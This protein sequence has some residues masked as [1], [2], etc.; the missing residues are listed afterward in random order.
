VI[1][2]VIEAKHIIHNNDSRCNK[3]QNISYTTVEVHVIEANI[4]HKIVKVHVI[5]AKQMVYNSD[6]TCNRCQT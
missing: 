2:H 6:T 1:V 3:G 4:R 5:E